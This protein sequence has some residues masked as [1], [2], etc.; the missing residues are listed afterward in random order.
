[1]HT[2]VHRSSDEEV[3]RQVTQRRSDQRF[4]V[5]HVRIQGLPS[6]SSSPNVDNIYTH[7]DPMQVL[8]IDLEPWASGLR[9]G[10]LS[11]DCRKQFRT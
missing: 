3:L 11:Q 8:S 9:V 1:M 2:Y 7:W 6:G 4:G 5:Q 10:S